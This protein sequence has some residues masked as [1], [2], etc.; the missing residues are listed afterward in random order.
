MSD[1]RTAA[2]APRGRLRRLWWKHKR[3][4]LEYE[5]FVDGGRYGDPRWFDV[6]AENDRLG[7]WS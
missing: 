5:L 3:R 4:N 6:K 2:M 7:V 1:M